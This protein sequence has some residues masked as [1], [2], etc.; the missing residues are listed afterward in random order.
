MM[1]LYTNDRKLR[2]IVES[3]A[4]QAISDVRRSDNCVFRHIVETK[5]AA[6]VIHSG[7]YNP[8]WITEAAIL[9]ST[10]CL[11]TQLSDL[12]TSEIACSAQLSTIPLSFLS[13][14]YKYIIFF[15]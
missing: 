13:F 10:I 12:L 3:C 6:S 9:V 7:L 2:G 14:V 1:Y 15:S 11:K 5:I 4:L 8:E